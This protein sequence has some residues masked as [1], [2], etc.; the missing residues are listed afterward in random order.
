MSLI[1]LATVLGF[2]SV[3]LLGPASV[4]LAEAAWVARAPRA[5]V[6]L[7]QCIGLS[8]VVAGIGTGLSVAVYRYHVGFAPGVRELAA[9]LVGGHPLQGLGLPDALGLTLAADLLIVLVVVSCSFAA[10]TIRTRARH[11]RLLDLLAIRSTEFPGTE[12]IDDQRPLAYC[13]PGRRPR[14]VISEGARRL[15]S[16]RQ[17]RAVIE[18]ERGHAR[19]HHGL[20]LLPMVG[21]AKI[22]GWIPYARLAPREIACLLEM[23]ADDFSARRSDPVSLATALVRMA[24][25]GRVP[26]CALAVSG[27]PVPQRV[28]RL[29]AASRTSKRAACVAAL[30]AGVVVVTPAV[31]IALF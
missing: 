21:I 18:H 11:R 8:A 17:L 4:R 7:W 16:P 12:L 1:A 22:F 10:G 15:L 29:L 27:N 20:V 26:S 13:L 19:A 5:A 25:S 28:S 31:V 2:F 3:V 23:S 9:G 30:V 14:I 24:T 6:I